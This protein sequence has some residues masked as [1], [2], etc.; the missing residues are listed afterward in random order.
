MLGGPNL[1]EDFM[2]DR[3][4]SGQNANGANGAGQP[5][6]PPEGI[7]RK[8]GVP[9]KKGASDMAMYAAI[10]GKAPEIDPNAGTLLEEVEARPAHPWSP[11]VLSLYLREI[12]RQGI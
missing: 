1:T 5:A 8:A 4:T 7:A 2:M 9:V 11:M 3:K 12:Y 6:S 10:A